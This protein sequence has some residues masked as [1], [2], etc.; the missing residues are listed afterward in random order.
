MVVEAGVSRGTVV[1]LL[2]EVKSALPSANNT[3]E[4]TNRFI[5][6]W[7][8]EASVSGAG[9]NCKLNRASIPTR[10]WRNSLAARG[11]PAAVMLARPLQ[12]R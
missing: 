5:I 8:D 6:L 10:T 11:D 12:F 1:W 9:K 7:S 3:A 4:I 2:Q